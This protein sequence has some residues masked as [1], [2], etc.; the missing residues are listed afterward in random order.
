MG[1]DVNQSLK[2]RTPTQLA[3]LG[4]R[5][6]AVAILRALAARAATLPASTN[7]EPTSGDAP[8]PPT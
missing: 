8:N 6:L 1:D 7:G 2:L 3:D 4:Q 5:L